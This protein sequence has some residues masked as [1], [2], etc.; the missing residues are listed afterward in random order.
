[1]TVEPSVRKVAKTGRDESS[2]ARRMIS[3][4]RVKSWD[5]PRK[6]PADSQAPS[7]RISTSSMRGCIPFK[8]RSKPKAPGLREEMKVGR[9]QSL[10]RAAESNT[11]SFYRKTGLSF[12]ATLAR[13][14]RRPL[15]K[16]FTP[17][18]PAVTTK[19]PT[20]TSTG[21]IRK[22]PVKPGRYNGRVENAQVF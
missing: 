21:E 8:A 4:A 17:Q 7:K 15:R 11:C 1:M 20:R 3:W 22:S 2:R 9:R 10:N 14:P 18:I 6:V 16:I 13:K 19:T 12:T 5:C